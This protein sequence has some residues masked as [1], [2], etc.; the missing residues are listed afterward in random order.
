[1]TRSRLAMLT[2]PLFALVLAAGCVAPGPAG[3]G[4]AVTVSENDCSVRAKA[5]SS[6]VPFAQAR[7]LT[8][9]NPDP[10]GPL[11]VGLRVRIFNLGDSADWEVSC[12]VKSPGAP[13][14]NLLWSSTL[15][16]TRPPTV[17]CVEWVE[18]GADWTQLNISA[19]NWSQVLAAFVDVGDADAEMPTRHLIGF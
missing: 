9:G 2:G 15:L 6:P 4:A 3:G 13:K 14:L 18:A 1:M 12:D 5:G 19:L 11:R 16:M 17:Q 7:Q 10:C 8:A